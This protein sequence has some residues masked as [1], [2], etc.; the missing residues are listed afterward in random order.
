[1]TCPDTSSRKSLLR[2]TLQALRNYDIRPRRKL[3]QSFLIDPRILSRYRA[4]LKL[5]NAGTSVFEA[6]AGLGVLTCELSRIT[7]IVIAVELDDRLIAPLRNALD[8]RANVAVVQ[9]DAVD[10]AKAV[11]ANVIASNLPYSAASQVLTSII[12]NNY[13]SGG[14]VM[15]QKEVALRLTAR[16]GSRDY[17]RLSTVFGYYFKA[18]VDSVYP[19]SSFY[20]RP[21]VE[22]ALVVLTRKKKWKPGDERFLELA[23]CIFTSPGRLAVKVLRR[24]GVDLTPD[25]QR[26][27]QGLRVRSL[28]PSQVYAIA[29]MAYSNPERR[30]QV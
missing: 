4:L 22:S 25:I 8:E 15:I 1:M 11:R 21:K 20:P 19:P 14:V 3:G 30:D 9:A 26:S 6:G 24:C 29:M 12:F 7:S 27:L 23:R 10:L 13:I 2:W 16:P 5:V 28:S 17:G 18:K